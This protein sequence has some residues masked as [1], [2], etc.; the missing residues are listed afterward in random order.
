[1]IRTQVCWDATIRIV[2]GAAVVGG[3]LVAAAA[4]FGVAVIGW[5]LA[6]MVAA[7]A[8]LFGTFLATKGL[9]L[10]VEAATRETV[11]GAPRSESLTEE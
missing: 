5:L 6:I 10:V 7:P 2:V 1:M 4:L 3:G 8:T 9:W 11:E